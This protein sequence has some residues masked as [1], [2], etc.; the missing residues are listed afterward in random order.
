M[1]NEWIRGILLDQIPVFH[2]VPHQDVAV[3]AG[4]RLGRWGM[5]KLQLYRVSVGRA[6]NVISILSIKLETESW[7]LL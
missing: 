4:G 3:P 2:G 6:V 7:H 1:V 5:T